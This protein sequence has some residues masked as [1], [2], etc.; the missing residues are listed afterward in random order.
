MDITYSDQER[1]ADGRTRAYAQY[2]VFEAF[3]SVAS[4]VRSIDVSIGRDRDAGSNDRITCTVL[5]YLRDGHRIEVTAGG[6]WPYAAI[7]QAAVRAR[8]QLDDKVTSCPKS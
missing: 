4:E 5:A 7:Q 1:A 6:D 3:R 8:R 2:R